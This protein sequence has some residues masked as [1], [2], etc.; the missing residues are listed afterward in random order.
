[1][2]KRHIESTTQRKS[3]TPQW[4][5]I[6]LYKGSIETGRERKSN[7]KVSEFLDL[8]KLYGKDRYNI[9]F[10]GIEAS[11]K[12]GVS[13][14]QERVQNP[15]GDKPTQRTECKKYHQELLKV[16]KKELGTVPYHGG[17]VGQL[18]RGLQG[19]RKLVS[20]STSFAASKV[21]S[22]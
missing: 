20:L 16:E 1:M 21:I 3:T 12:Q 18:A 15:K 13:Q 4:E 5:D 22:A 10:K 9:D 17:N 6:E 19:G 11:R 14:H 7:L 2:Y 8:V